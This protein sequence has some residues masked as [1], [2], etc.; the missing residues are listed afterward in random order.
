M[1]K[2]LQILC[3][4]LVAIGICIESYFKA[5]IGF[6]LITCGSLAFAISCKLENR[7]TKKEYI[8]KEDLS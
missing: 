6:I 1:K 2:Y 3:I 4:V 7:P 8:E 5:N